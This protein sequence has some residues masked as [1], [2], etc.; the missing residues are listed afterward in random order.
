M[1]KTLR[2][3]NLFFWEGVWP[4]EKWLWTNESPA[5]EYY[6]FKW[7]HLDFLSVIHTRFAL[8]VITDVWSQ[9]MKFVKSSKVSVMHPE[10]GNSQDQ[11]IELIL[12]GSQGCV[13]PHLSLSKQVQLLKG[14]CC[15][16][17][18][19]STLRAQQLQLLR[20]YLW[21][22]KAEDVESSSTSAH[23]FLSWFISPSV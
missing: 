17:Q 18:L 12:N 3:K 22:K 9:N 14:L 6:C 21:F 7:F 1:S 11:L 19:R 15:S 4:L 2:Q 8:K 13:K 5:S 20:S 16:P 10:N 23:H